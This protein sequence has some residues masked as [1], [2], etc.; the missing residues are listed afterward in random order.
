M[1]ILRNRWFLTI[2]KLAFGFG[3]LAY[4]VNSGK[5]DFKE[6]IMLLMSPKVGIPVFI[7]FSFSLM[8]SSYRWMRILEFHLEKKLNL[9]MIVLIQWIGGFFSAA[10]PGVVT[11]DILKLTFLKKQDA[12]LS[13]RYMLFSIFL[14]R[15]LGLFALLFLAGVAS[16]VF[17]IDLVSLSPNFEN[18][19]FVNSLL[20]LAA[21][22]ALMVFLLPEKLQNLV[23]RI[24]IQEKIQNTL[25]HLWSL[26]Q[27]RLDFFKLFLLSV[28]SH[29]FSIGAFHLINLNSYETPLPFSFLFSTIP[30]GQVATALPIAP[31][32]LGVGHAAYQTLFMYLHQNNGATLFNN[33]WIFVTSF[34]VLGVIPYFFL[35]HKQ[36]KSEVTK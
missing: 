7:L 29:V 17:Y 30:L 20:F 8:I 12:H 22:L 14:D 1:E 10:L 27:R 21:L 9:P 11:G 2:L 24:V 13:K 25:K 23:L 18:I 3:L 28:L 32:G 5:V 31:S 4:L 34:Y 33:Y 19:I 35:S 15:L 26:S 6:A 36:T 16:F